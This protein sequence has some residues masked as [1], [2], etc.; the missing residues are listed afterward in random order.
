MMSFEM[1]TAL[2]LFALVS[3]ITPGPN[4]LILMSSGANFGFKRTTPHMFG[5]TLGFMLMLF[6]VGLGIMQLFDL[7]PLSYLILKVFC[8]VYLL[9]LAY[10]IATSN[11]QQHTK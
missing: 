10:K 9:Y 2:A 11:G 7:F 6:L 8:V 5:V 4:N 3:S 1:M